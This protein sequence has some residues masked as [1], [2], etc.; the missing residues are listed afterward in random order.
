MS[1]TTTCTANRTASHLW[2]AD[3]EATAETLCRRAV[4]LGGLAVNQPN[5]A[6]ATNEY[7]EMARQ[8]GAAARSAL[9]ARLE[10]CLAAA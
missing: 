8:A 10:L 2:A 9:T 3:R 7:K 4:R 6:Q 1:P 5:S